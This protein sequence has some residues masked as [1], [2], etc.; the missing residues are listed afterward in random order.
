MS[1][2]GPLLPLLFCLGACNMVYSETPMFTDADRHKLAPRDGI[3]LAEIKDCPV[4]SAM[5][6]STW[7]ECAMWLVARDSGRD[8]LLSDGKGQT[9][10]IVALYAAGTPMIAQGRWI[11]DAKD[12]ATAH[13]GF[14]GLEPNSSGSDDRFTAAITWPVECGIKE[15]GQSAIKPFPGISPECRPSSKDAI[16]AAA[17]ASDRSEQMS[18][19]WI[20]AETR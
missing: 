6:E 15:P 18:W 19:R 2:R 4:D 10:R 9:Q 16:R 13:Y 11:D 14:Q 5:P 1:P 3:W 20:R 17:I 8:L 7:P 12:P